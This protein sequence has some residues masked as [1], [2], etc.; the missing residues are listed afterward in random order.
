MVMKVDIYFDDD[1]HFQRH[2]QEIE[3]KFEKRK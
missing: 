2:G 1:V 3:P